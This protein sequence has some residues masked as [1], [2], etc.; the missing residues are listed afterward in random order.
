VAQCVVDQVPERL[1]QAQ[2]VR[3]HRQL[4][5]GLDPQGAAAL[6]RAIDEAVANAPEQLADR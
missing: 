4:L 5:A 6:G 1:A 3:V 2:R